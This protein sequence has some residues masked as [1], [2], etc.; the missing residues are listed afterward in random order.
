MWSIEPW[1]DDLEGHLKV[2]S[3]TYSVSTK[4]SQ[5]LLAQRHHSAT[6]RSNFW[7]NDLRDNCESAM[8]LCLPAH[9]RNATLKFSGLV[10]FSWT[11]HTVYSYCYLM[12]AQL[13]HDVLATAELLVIPR[14][15]ACVKA[16]RAT[17]AVARFVVNKT[18]ALDKCTTTFRLRRSFVR[19]N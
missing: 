18:G 16:A 7:H 2:I 14:E 17:S 6:K 3:V 5:L 12:C 1:R 10:L 19:P 15:L 8:W 4:Q 9:R 13:T 11:Q